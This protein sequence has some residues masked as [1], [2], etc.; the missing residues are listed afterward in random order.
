MAAKP[1][2][3]NRPIGLGPKCGRKSTA[4]IVPMMPTGTLMRKISRQS[5]YST[6]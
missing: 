4:A 5:T 2:Q 1:S 6:R 3:S